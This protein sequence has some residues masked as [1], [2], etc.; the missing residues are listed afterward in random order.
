MKDI[1]NFIN[2]NDTLNEAK[3]DSILGYYKA[4]IDDIC[5]LIENAPYGSYTLNSSD[6]ER[7]TEDILDNLRYANSTVN[8]ESM[9]GNIDTGDI[10]KDAKLKAFISKSIMEAIYAS[11]SNDYSVNSEDY[12]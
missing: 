9:D 6:M 2:E 5:Y 1:K 3:S 7:A 11:V 12:S 10:K 8:E 4:V